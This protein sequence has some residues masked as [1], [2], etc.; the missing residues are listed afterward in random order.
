MNE[1]TSGRHSADRILQDTY[2]KHVREGNGR[3]LYGYADLYITS[4]D[5]TTKTHIFI[6]RF[7]NFLPITKH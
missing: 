4:H 6:I 3:V 7:S 1:S 2:S 5:V